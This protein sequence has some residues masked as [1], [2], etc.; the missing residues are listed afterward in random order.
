MSCPS[1]ADSF[2]CGLV[3]GEMWKSTNAFVIFGHRVIIYRSKMRRIYHKTAECSIA[4][5]RHDLF[6]WVD[7]E[8]G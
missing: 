6:N 2:I 7:G 3:V 4:L 8:F 1:R 5:M